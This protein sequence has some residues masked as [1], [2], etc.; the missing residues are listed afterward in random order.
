MRKNAHSY[1]V[2]YKER[3]LLKMKE[4]A[5]YKEILKGHKKDTEDTKRTKGQSRKWH[6]SQV[7]H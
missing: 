3:W 1:Q 6:N 2:R 4:G 5:K 7:K